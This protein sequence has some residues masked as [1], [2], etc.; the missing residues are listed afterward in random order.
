VV[1]ISACSA[2]VMVIIPVRI[3]NTPDAIN[4]P[5]LA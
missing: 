5:P 2:A 1:M 4:N 3:A